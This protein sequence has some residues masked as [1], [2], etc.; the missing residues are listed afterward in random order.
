M[1]ACSS[2]PEAA[3]RRSVIDPIEG[4]VYQPPALR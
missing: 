3:E 4:R 1:R 2:C